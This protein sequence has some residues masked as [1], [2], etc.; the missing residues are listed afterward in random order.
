MCIR[1]R[2][3]VRSVDAKTGAERWNVTYGEVHPLTNPGPRGAATLVARRRDRRLVDPDR[4]SEGSGLFPTLRFES[5]NAVTMTSS[6]G[7]GQTTRWSRTF[8]STPLSAF[9]GFG[10]GVISRRGDGGGAEVFVGAHAGGLYALPG[11]S[12]ASNGQGGEASP[13]ERTHESDQNRGLV[14]LLRSGFGETRTPIC[15][16]YTSPSPRD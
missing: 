13:D 2:Y 12:L 5:G 7:P 3:K 9:E 14:T 4:D 1:D 16:L 6:P 10:A 11:P 15:L 8:P